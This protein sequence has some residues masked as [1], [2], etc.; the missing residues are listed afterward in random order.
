MC[1]AYRH[2]YS[3]TWRQNGWGP[4]GDAENCFP[5]PFCLT[6]WGRISQEN[7]DALMWIALLASLLRTSAVSVF[8][9]CNYGYHLTF[10]W[11]WEPEPG[12]YSQP[13][14]TEPSPQPLVC[15]VYWEIWG[16]FPNIQR[17][18]KATAFW[19]TAHHFL[20]VLIGLSE[21]VVNQW[22]KLSWRRGVYLIYR[23]YAIIGGNLG[24]NSR[25]GV[26]NW[27]KDCWGTLLTGWLP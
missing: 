3:Y 11:V 26:R 17:A 23:L 20:T 12:L 8:W 19:R 4:E 1:V 24:R 5:S 2:A 27:I 14:T 25:Q 15:I 9:V 16:N 7:P 22:S 10:T 21:T 18:W 13:L 6:L